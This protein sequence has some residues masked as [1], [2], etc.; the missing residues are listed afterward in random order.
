MTAQ[1]S[2]LDGLLQLID[3]Q[4]D[5]DH[6]EQVDA[7]YR[8]ALGGEVTDRPPLVVQTQ[9]DGNWTLPKPWD[10]FEHYRNR[11]AY[12]DPVA[13]MQNMLLE[14]VV[15]GLI[16]KDDNP[17]AIRNNHGTIQGRQL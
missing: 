13:M 1:I 7:R 4:I 17:L 9:W 5:L 14:R 12:H 11:Q 3:D 16:L 2:Q 8:R 15:P 6:C 10:Q